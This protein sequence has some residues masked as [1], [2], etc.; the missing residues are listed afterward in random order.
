MG[1]KMGILKRKG[2]IVGPVFNSRSNKRGE[3]RE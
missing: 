2:A 1:P 3:N